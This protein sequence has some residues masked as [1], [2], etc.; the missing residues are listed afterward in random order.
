MSPAVPSVV[1]VSS[2]VPSAVLVSSAISSVLVSH[3]VPSAVL[4]CCCSSLDVPLA[5][6]SL[7]LF[8]LLSVW[9]PGRR[10]TTLAG[11]IAIVSPFRHLPRFSSPRLLASGVEKTRALVS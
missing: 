3:A 7:V 11:L 10:S 4:V 9:P 6:L 8:L 2:A 1:L 5:D